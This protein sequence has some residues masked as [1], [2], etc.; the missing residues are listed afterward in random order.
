[1]GRHALSGWTTRA[2]HDPAVFYFE[3]EEGGDPADGNDDKEAKN[4][5]QSCFRRGSLLHPLKR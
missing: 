4:E 5:T 1:M 2:G 3:L